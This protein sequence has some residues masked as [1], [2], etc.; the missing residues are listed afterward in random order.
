MKG[1]M[2]YHHHRLEMLS[3]RVKE[4]ES[5]ARASTSASNS[6]DRR[7]K[8]VRIQFTNRL[9]ILEEEIFEDADAYEDAITR[10]KESE[11]PVKEKPVERPA[12]V[13]P[14]P[15]SY[16]PRKAE[17]FFDLDP[18]ELNCLQV[19]LDHLLESLE[20]N[21]DFSRSYMEIA[22]EIEARLS[23]TKKM[24]AFLK[25]CEDLTLAKEWR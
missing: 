12:E 6:F 13:E 7:I 11:I 19:A 8:D 16:K 25:D 14:D 1:K 22:D 2:S 21:D 9:E 17:D 5:F 18:L 3:E 23:C 10:H 20:D 4:L 15:Y 24:I